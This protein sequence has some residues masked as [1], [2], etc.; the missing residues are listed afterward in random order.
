MDLK[1][2]MVILLLKQYWKP[3]KNMNIRVKCIA[4][5]KP[6]HIKDWGGMVKQGLFHSWLPCLVTLLD[7]KILKT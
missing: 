3:R 2:K 4:C 7:K 1:L 5:K 6:I